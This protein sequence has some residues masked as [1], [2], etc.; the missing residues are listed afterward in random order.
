VPEWAEIL[1]ASLRSPFSMSLI[2]LSIHRRFARAETDPLKRQFPRI[3]REQR[4]ET[5]NAPRK[6]ILQPRPG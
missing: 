4:M 5:R 2:L 6:V 1:S 3:G